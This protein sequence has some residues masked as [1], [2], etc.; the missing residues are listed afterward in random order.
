[1]KKLSFKHK[2]ALVELVIVLLLVAYFFCPRPL[3]LAFGGA[4]D[5]ERITGVQVDLLPVGTQE[6][7]SRTIQLEPDDPACGELLEYLSGKWYLPYY[8]E[9]ENRAATLDYTV[10]IT[11]GQP[12]RVSTYWFYGDRAIDLGGSDTRTRTYQVTDSESF[13]QSL[14]DFLLQQEYTIQE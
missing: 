9:A 13:Q 5:Q 7:E 3:H 12:D 8:L 10:H 2:I 1:M 4:F 14:L 6:R 11:L